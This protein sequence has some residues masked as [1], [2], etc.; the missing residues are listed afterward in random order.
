MVI[1]QQGRFEVFSTGQ[2]GKLLNLGC[3][4][5]K[6]VVQSLLELNDNKHSEAKPGGKKEGLNPLGWSIGGSLLIYWRGSHSKN[7]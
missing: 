7:R 1:S 6:L 2:L 3:I 4:P 5:I